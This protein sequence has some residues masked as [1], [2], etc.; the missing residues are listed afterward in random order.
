MVNNQGISLI[1]L[2]VTIIVAVILSI[3][4]IRVGT[5]GI[6]TSTEARIINEK[7]E[8]ETAIVRRFADYSINEDA[9]PLIGA[10]V[11]EGDINNIDGIH[12]ENIGYIRRIDKTN[13]QGLGLK[14]ST[15]KTYIVDYL[16]GKV[17][18]PID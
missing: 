18:G 5:T 14:N 13:S 10:E 11:T 2:I 15:G 7:K 6:D 12:T 9:Y 8:I 16:L 1:A 4:T 3:I 17:Y